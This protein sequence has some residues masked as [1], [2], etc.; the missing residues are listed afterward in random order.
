MSLWGEEINVDCMSM[1]DRTWSVRSDLPPEHNLLAGYMHSGISTDRH[2]I[3]MAVAD[4]DSHRE[5]PIPP[6]TGTIVLDGKEAVV[7]RGVRRVTDRTAGNPNRI[8]IELTDALDRELRVT[9]EAL[10]HL[11]T[12]LNPAIFNTWS[13]YRW[14]E[15]DGAV[16]YGESQETWIPLPQYQRVRHELRK[17]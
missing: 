5:Q 14:T 9:G 17:A 11:K 6:G 8:E 16:G 10:N 3:V 13:L 2:W 12:M 7:K 1:R 4:P 15:G